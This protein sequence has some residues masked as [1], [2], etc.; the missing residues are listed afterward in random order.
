[1]D[2][3]NDTKEKINASLLRLKRIATIFLVISFALKVLEYLGISA[4]KSNYSLT[5][6]YGWLNLIFNSFYLLFTTF[7]HFYLLVTVFGMQNVFR[8][9]GHVK[10]YFAE[11]YVMTLYLAFYGYLAY[12]YVLKPLMVWRINTTDYIC[13]PQMRKAIAILNSW[14]D[15]VRPICF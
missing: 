12:W 7:A 4:I 10:G 1:M 3:R 5:P 6:E 9:F 8:K 2:T 15:S 13:T 11:V 14:Q